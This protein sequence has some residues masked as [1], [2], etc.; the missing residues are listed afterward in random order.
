MTSDLVDAVREL[1]E[2]QMRALDRAA[3]GGINEALVAAIQNIEAQLSN[4]NVTT[5]TGE[6]V[7]EHEYHDWRR[8]AVYARQ[9]MLGQLRMV[10][11]VIKESGAGR[12]DAINWRLRYHLRSELFTR[13]HRTERHD[14]DSWQECG[15]CQTQFEALLE[16]ATQD[17]V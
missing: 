7:S 16:R 17:V 14:G 11:R 8:R 6:R 5:P 12:D 13:V 15:D 4:Q 1:T 3:L 10:K 2:E 9:K